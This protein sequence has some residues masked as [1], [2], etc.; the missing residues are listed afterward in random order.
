MYV[1]MVILYGLLC[2]VCGVLIWILV[3]MLLP[4][5]P[6]EAA[7]EDASEGDEESTVKGEEHEKTQSPC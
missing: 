1:L 5:P 2:L 4:G 7:R 6:E 3:R